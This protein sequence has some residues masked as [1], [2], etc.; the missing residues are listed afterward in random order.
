VG[1]SADAGHCPAGAHTPLRDQPP[2]QAPNAPGENRP[3]VPLRPALMGP[4][5][6][7]IDPRQPP[8]WARRPAR[9]WDPT[10]QA[11][12]PLALAS[13]V[14]GSR[15]PLLASLKSVAAV[16]RF[17]S[18]DQRLIW[19]EAKPKVSLQQP[20]R[21]L[22]VPRADRDNCFPAALMARCL[23]RRQVCWAQWARWLA[24]VLWSG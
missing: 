11:K 24:P 1:K 2:L 7:E 22:R 19:R 4:P 6:P 15:E 17:R 21:T 18:G 14:L 16:S 9:L 8:R 13:L 3:A 12:A 23:F 10:P 5:P 20:S